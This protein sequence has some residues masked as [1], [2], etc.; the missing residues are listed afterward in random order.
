MND[1]GFP[2]LAVDLMGL[3]QPARISLTLK[4]IDA[5]ENLF[6]LQSQG[7]RTRSYETYHNCYSTLLTSLNALLHPSAPT[8]F[9]F[10][11]QRA[12]IQ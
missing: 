12:D 4:D 3:S 10:V 2:P 8:R 11:V 5:E 1:I 6:Q 7:A 9:R